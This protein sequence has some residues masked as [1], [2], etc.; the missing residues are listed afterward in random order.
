MFQA[1][2]EP[3]NTAVSKNSS[4]P[5]SNGTTNTR[6]KS[7]QGKKTVIPGIKG[8]KTI[9]NSCTCELPSLFCS[10]IVPLII[11]SDTMVFYLVKTLCQ[12]SL[13]KTNMIVVCYVCL[14]QYA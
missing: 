10:Q 8:K 6:G 7:K 3:P 2:E 4:R 12:I 13:I 5:H 11:F 1:K 14:R 9:D